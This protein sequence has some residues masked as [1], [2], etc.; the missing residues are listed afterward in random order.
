MIT[1][2]DPDRR[3]DLKTGP[4]PSQPSEV[5]AKQLDL[6]FGPLEPTE[7]LTLLRYCVAGDLVFTTS[8]G[9]EDQVLTHL[10][11][12]SGV[13][14]RFV[15][16]DTGRMFGETYA[17]WARTEERYGI[18]IRGY[19]PQT[20]AVEGLVEQHGIDGFYGSRAARN[21]CCAIRKVEPLARALTNATGWITGLRA[22]QSASRQGMDFVSHD[23]ARGLVKANPLF[24]WSRERLAALA[25]AEDIP[26][27]PLHTRGFLS[28]GCA[29]C[30]RAVA[31]GESER[32]GRWWWEEET[33]K[34]CG[35]HV[36]PE[37]R[38]VRAGA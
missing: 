22:D 34:E 14:V 4:V 12:K 33:A 29:P 3:D 20:M 17:L 11:A 13:G 8:F 28:I 36:T 10:I 38:L 24:D 6:A 9:L 2:L 16:L 30:T 26:I 15:T 21:A 35:L 27:N 23:P 1:T 5:L 25:A 7:R 18:R 32:A 37:G 19:Y 31:P